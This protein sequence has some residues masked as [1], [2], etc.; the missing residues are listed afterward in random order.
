MFYIY[1]EGSFVGTSEIWVELPQGYTM[2]ET[3]PDSPVD[4][5][6]PPDNPEIPVVTAPTLSKFEEGDIQKLRGLI[7]NELLANM[8][9]LTYHFTQGD[10]TRC[11]KLISSIKDIA[12]NATNKHP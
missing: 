1:Y 4:P 10:I 11:N 6:K 2:S 12:N 9:E 3:P 8:L 5:I 7:G